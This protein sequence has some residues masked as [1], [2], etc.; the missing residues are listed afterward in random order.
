MPGDVKITRI[1]FLR[2]LGIMACTPLLLPLA[3]SCIDNT[4][5]PASEEQ[6][7]S[8]AS[9]IERAIIDQP[10]YIVPVPVAK[11]GEQGVFEV[12][13][14]AVHSAKDKWFGVC[15]VLQDEGGVWLQI[16]QVK[17]VEKVADRMH[18]TGIR[19]GD[20][21]LLDMK[22]SLVELRRVNRVG[23][24]RRFLSPR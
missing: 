10:T 4:E 20:K 9:E 16:V 1:C 22:K 21:L 11:S 8:G 2:S 15:S 23:L 17:L 5:G 13:S 18:V 24:T 19:S 12:P 6:R 7:E 3:E 14:S